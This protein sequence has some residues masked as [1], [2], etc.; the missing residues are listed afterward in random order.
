M[1]DLSLVDWKKDFITKR[2]ITENE[3][4]LRAPSRMTPHQLAVACTYCETI[5]NPFAEQLTKRAGNIEAFRNALDIKEKRKALD[6][7]CAAFGIKL[8]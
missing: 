2:Y 6:R 1:A 7:A 8:F 5:N 3:N 4:L